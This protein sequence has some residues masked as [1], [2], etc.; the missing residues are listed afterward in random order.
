MTVKRSRAGSSSSYN[1][2]PS[3]TPTASFISPEK[4]MKTDGVAESSRPKLLAVASPENVAESDQLKI[5]GFLERCHYCKKRIAQNSE[6]FM[7][8]NLC[9]FC[10]AECRDSQIAL[11]QSAKKKPENPKGKSV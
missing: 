3:S 1:E 5:G 8:S 9:A 4:V 7:Y 6:V 10:S 11:D 2:T